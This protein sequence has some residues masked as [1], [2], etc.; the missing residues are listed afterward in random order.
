MFKKILFL[1][2]MLCPAAPLAAAESSPKRIILDEKNTIVLRGEVTP[3]STA[4]VAADLLSHPDKTVYLYISSPGGS[5]EAGL[6]LIDIIKNSGKNVKCIAGFAA[7]MAFA[8]LQVCDERL[9]LERSVLMQH[10]PSYGLEGEAPN[11]LSMVQ[12]ITRMTKK[13]DEDQAKRIGMTVEA[14]RAKIR[15]DWWLFGSEAVESNVADSVVAASCSP[16][17]TK[18]RE[19]ETIRTPAWTAEVEWSGCPLIEVPVKINADNELS[20]EF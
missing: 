17:T 11:N 18:R 8:I 19:K 2:T 14:F 20:E 16:S 6:A 5:V 4:K 15:D 13:L 10:V 1:A 3:E 9:V 12:F 7:S